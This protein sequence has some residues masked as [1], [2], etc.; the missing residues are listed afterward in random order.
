MNAESHRNRR[1]R[2]VAKKKHTERRSRYMD[3]NTILQTLD[4]QHVCSARCRNACL[5]KRNPSQ[6]SNSWYNLEY[7]ISLRNLADPVGKW[8]DLYRTVDDYNA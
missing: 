5:T 3:A 2:G 1:V 8:C 6:S 7:I 4:Q